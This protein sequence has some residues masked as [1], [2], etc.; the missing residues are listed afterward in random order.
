[1]KKIGMSIII[2][3]SSILGAQTKQHVDAFYDAVRD[4]NF[5]LVK[6]M[7]EQEGYPIKAV[8]PQQI[9]PVKAAIWKKNLPMVEY[10]VSKGANLT[11]DTTLV[12]TAIEYGSP[13][14]TLYLLKKGL[15]A[16]NALSKAVFYEN[17]DIAKEV[18]L[19]YQPQKIDNEYMG[20]FLLLAAK[21]NDLEFI[22]KLPLKGKDSPMDYFDY[23]GYNALLYA[24]EKNYTELA[25]Y[26]LSQG[27]DKKSTI[28]IETDN[29][30]VSGKTAMQ[31]AKANKNTELIKLL[32]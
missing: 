11:A 1:M 32:K 6:K 10:M 5:P 31:L 18:Y 12:D 25:K 29:G 3:L 2:C 14:I 17:L 7:V 15:Y 21:N 24:V 4:D 26:L 30:I 8:I 23:D 28:S 16:K 27:A 22:K 19:N 13:E 20:R 9:L